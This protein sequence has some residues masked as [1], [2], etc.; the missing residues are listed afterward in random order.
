VRRHATVRRGTAAAA[1]V[2]L[3][4]RRRS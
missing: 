3:T 4:P 2:A 1:R